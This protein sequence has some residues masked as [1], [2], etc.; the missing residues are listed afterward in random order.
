MPNY[1]VSFKISDRSLVNI[2]ILDTS[3]HEQYKSLNEN[4]Y[5]IGD[6]ILLVYDIT[7]RHSFDECIFYYNE[8][9]KERCKKILKFF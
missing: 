9:I 5:K 2:H 1:F 4:Y 6:C 7:N 8:C 3:G